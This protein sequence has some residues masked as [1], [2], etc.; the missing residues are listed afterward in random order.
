MSITT[1]RTSLTDLEHLF[2]VADGGVLAQDFKSVLFR[3]LEGHA[4]LTIG[5]FS[6]S[7]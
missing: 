1:E 5:T 2:E 7:L 3:E 4:T 6:P